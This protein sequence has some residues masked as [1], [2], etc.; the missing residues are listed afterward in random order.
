M[1]RLI[2]V[3][4]VSFSAMNADSAGEGAKRAK[5]LLQKIKIESPTSTKALVMPEKYKHIQDLADNI[6]EKN[7]LITI[8]YL[9]SSS[10]PLSSH[11][12][13]AINAMKLMEEFNL[14][15]NMCMI[16]IESKKFPSFISGLMSE[17]DTIDNFDASMEF[18]PE[19][20]ETLDVKR[21]PAY[22]VSVCENKNLHPEECEVKY[23]V[24]GDITLKY[25]LEKLSEKNKYFEEFYNA[26]K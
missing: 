6:K 21:V 25:M 4:L 16:G 10:V 9:T 14:Q 1:C 18:C 15:A 19:L 24:R 2:L 12:S 5:M 22:A 7:P 17:L 26:L 20:F 8:T 13:Y 23:L 11:Q 3:F